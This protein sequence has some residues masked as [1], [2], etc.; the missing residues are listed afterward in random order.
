MQHRDSHRVINGAVQTLVNQQSTAA[1]QFFGYTSTVSDTNGPSCTISTALVN[2]NSLI[3]VSPEYF[4][5]AAS[6]VIGWAVMSKSPG[7]YFRLA[8]ANSTTNVGS[9]ILGWELKNPK[10]LIG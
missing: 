9:F 4:G 6:N 7:G 1:N 3:F 8:A 10:S 5:A 2:S